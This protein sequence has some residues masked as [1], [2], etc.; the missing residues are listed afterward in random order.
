M[1]SRRWLQ[2]GGPVE[3]AAEATTE[4]GAAAEEVPDVAE[5][6]EVRRTRVKTVARV[7][8]KVKAVPK[9]VR[10]V[11]GEE[12]AMLT[13]LQIVPAPCI[14]VGGVLRIFVPNLSHVPGRITSS[15]DR[16]IIITNE[17]LTSSKR[18]LMIVI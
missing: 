17:V 16:R 7:R 15:Q 11:A 13:G 2:S 6:D 1:L 10:E 18:K 5:A 14:S 12:P 8:V 9:V 3:A 4:V